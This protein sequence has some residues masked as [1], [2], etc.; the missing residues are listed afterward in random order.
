MLSGSTTK[1]ERECQKDQFE[2]TI[3]T[4]SRRL[5]WFSKRALEKALQNCRLVGSRVPEGQSTQQ[6]PRLGEHMCA[7]AEGEHDFEQNELQMRVRWGVTHGT[8]ENVAFERNEPR[9]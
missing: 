7:R 2:H 3:L 8:L 5:L 6:K 9:E 4:L 1:P